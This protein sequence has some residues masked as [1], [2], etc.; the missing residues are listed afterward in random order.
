MEVF[1]EKQQNVKRKMSHKL[2]QNVTKYFKIW[3]NE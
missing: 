2:W 3:Q 1:L